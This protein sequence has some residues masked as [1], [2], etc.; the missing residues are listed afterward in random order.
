M[1]GPRRKSEASSDLIHI[2]RGKVAKSQI[3]RVVTLG[4]VVDHEAC[5]PKDSLIKVIISNP[6]NRSLG[7]VSLI[8]R[9]SKYPVAQMMKTLLLRNNEVNFIRIC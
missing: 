8:T 2:Y 7:R 5:P 3:I 1:S 4:V 6:D 9:L